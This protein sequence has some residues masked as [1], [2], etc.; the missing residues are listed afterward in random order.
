[1]VYVARNGFEHLSL[2]KQ[3]WRHPTQHTIVLF[4]CLSFFYSGV[5]YVFD[6]LEPVILIYFV[7][8][9]SH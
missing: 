7:V 4:V 2:V 5:L 1:M 6:S 3:R 8:F 9:L